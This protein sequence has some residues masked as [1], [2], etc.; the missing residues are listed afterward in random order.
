MP[1]ISILGTGWGVKVQALAFKSAGWDLHAI[2]GRSQEKAQA[3]QSEFGFA[4]APQDWREALDGADLVSIT[5]PPFE[6]LEQTLAALQNGNNVLCEKPMAMSV[7]EAQ[8][9]VQA[10]QNAKGWALVD[11]ELRFLPVRQ[12]MRDLIANGAIGELR[13]AEVR[14]VSGSRA[15]PNR[16]YNWW[17]SRAMGGGVL[18]AA[19]SH[20]LDGLRFVLGREATLL[21]AQLNTAVRQLPDSSGAMQ[22]VDSDDYA[23]M[24]LD[25]SGIPTT[26]L[27]NVAARHGFEDVLLVHGAD[28]TLALRGGLKLEHAKA[29]ETVW[30]D[31]S[32]EPTQGIPDGIGGNGFEVGTV[33]IARY[34]RQVLEQG[35]RP[36]QGA[37]LEDG[38][39]VQ[40][41]MDAARVSSGWN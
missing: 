33:L 7:Q 41:L 5:T 32:P 15:D 23:A 21:G 25:F 2:W 4:H 37:T 11:H 19:G 14:L 36:D 3:A 17:S 38:L 8:T 1:K 30:Q 31:I 6:H 12:K 26:V 27:M 10:A 24:L 40:S 9:M 39:K 13:A 29:G 18:G 34:L 28:G 16:A 20:V 35:V 22:T